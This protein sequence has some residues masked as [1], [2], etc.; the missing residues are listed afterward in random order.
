[1]T[2]EELE[3][4]VKSLKQQMLTIASRTSERDGKTESGLTDVSV[5]TD[6]LKTETEAAISEAWNPKHIYVKDDYVFYGNGAWICDIQNEDTPPST[7]SPYWHKVNI[8][9][10]LNRLMKLIKE[11]ENNV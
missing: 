8:V 10:E 11:K 1:M 5:K 7:E 3:V 9:G 2:H 6:T 4:E